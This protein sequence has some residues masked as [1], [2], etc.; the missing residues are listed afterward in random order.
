MKAL[1]TTFRIGTPEDVAEVFHLYQAVGQLEGGLARAAE[2][3]TANYVS[4]FCMAASE[5]GLQLL[6]FNSNGMLIAEIHAYAIGP[7]SFKHVYSN[8]TIAVHPSMQG[9][10]IGKLLFQNFLALI[11]NE[12]QHILRVELIARSSNKRAIELYQQLGFVQEGIMK[13]RICSANHQL[14]DDIPMAWE[15]T[16]FKP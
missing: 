1:E 5:K 12:R 9:R 7:K 16:T 8:L 13:N 15:N 3:I 2:E 4:D 6:A 11:S 14:E 10:G